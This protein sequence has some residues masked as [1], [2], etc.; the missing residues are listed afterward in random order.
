MMPGNKIPVR[1]SLK[2][3]PRRKTSMALVIAGLMI[4]TAMISGSLVTG[5]TL[6][7]LFTR[8][9]YFGYGHADEVVY[10][11]NSTTIG[12]QGSA[13]QYFAYNVYQSLPTGLSNIPSAGPDV[14]R[15]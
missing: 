7:E 2:N 4:G 3:F 9:A 6:T 10:A 8:G 11:R 12:F 1:M 14:V 15:V 13:Y 5:D